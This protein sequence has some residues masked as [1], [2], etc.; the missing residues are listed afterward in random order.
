MVCSLQGLKEKVDQ[1]CRCKSDA[2]RIDQPKSMMWKWFA[3][4]PVPNSRVVNATGA[5][6]M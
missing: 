3:V 2:S 1:A 5:V 4:S 6:G